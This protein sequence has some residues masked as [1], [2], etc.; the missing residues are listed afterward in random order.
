MGILVVG[1]S[2]YIGKL[3]FTRVMQEFAVLGTSS[4]GSDNFIPFRLDA[5]KKFDYDLIKEFDIVFLTA[6]ISAPDICSRERVR[7]W[8]VNV[9][10]TSI[11]ISEVISRGGR[12]VF[13]SSDTVYGER[14]DEFDE[15][16]PCD[17][18][19]EYAKMKHEVET[20]FLGNPSFKTIRLSYV[21]SKEDKFTTYLSEC[22]ERGDVVEIFQPFYMAIVH[23]N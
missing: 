11:F 3:L 4:S 15:T 23:R 1:A 14:K 20:R 16:S 8:N 21:F 22:A 12:I 6:A 10:G 19:G 18:S 17:P 13:F 9:T 5:P 2:G 7:A